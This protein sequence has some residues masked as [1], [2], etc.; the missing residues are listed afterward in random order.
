MPAV[1]RVTVADSGTTDTTIAVVITP[2]IADNT[3]V[4]FKCDNLNIDLTQATQNNAVSFLLTT[5]QDAN[6][7]RNSLH[8][9]TIQVGAAQPVQLEIQVV[10][11]SNAYTLGIVMNDDIR[12]TSSGQSTTPYYSLLML[13]D[14]AATAR[15]ILGVGEI[16]ELSFITDA[17]AGMIPSPSTSV[18]YYLDT[19]TRFTA[20]NLFFSQQAT[21][22]SGTVSVYST[23]STG[24]ENLEG[25]IT[26]TTSQSDVSLGVGGSNNVGIQPGRQIFLRFSSA[27]VTN[28]AFNL[29]FNRVT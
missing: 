18:D 6:I 5:L 27:G 15:G 14:D 26:I 2:S 7:T 17:Y 1:E 12:V 11:G 24:A 10:E 29:G 22:A 13:A 25:T 3:D 28:F 20:S 19:K 21:A 16:G 4:R 23:T 9:A 8:D